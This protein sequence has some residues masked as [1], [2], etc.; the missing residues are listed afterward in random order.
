MLPLDPTFPHGAPQ[1]VPDRVRALVE[2][3]GDLQKG[4]LHF[5]QGSIIVEENEQNEHVY[6]I[7]D[8][9]VQMLKHSSINPSLEVDR[10]GPGDLLGLTSFWSRE[11]SFLRSVALTEVRCLAIDSFDLDQLTRRDPEVRLIIHRLFISNLSNRYRRMISLNVRVAELGD[12]LHREHAQLK[13]AIHDLEQTRNRLIHQEKLATLGQLLAGIAHEINNPCAA[14]SQGVE[15]LNQ[16]LPQLLD[17]THA[18]PPQPVHLSLFLAGL[19]ASYPTTEDKRSRRDALLSRHPELP[20]SLARRLARLAPDLLPT[21]QLPS[22]GSLKSKDLQRI[23]SL[24]ATYELGTHLRS[25]RLSSERIQ[26]LVVSLKNYGRQDQP[27]AEL[28]DLRDGIHDTLT[29]LNHRLKNYQLS[30]DLQ[31]IPKVLVVGSEINQVWT[32]L[33]TNACQATPTGGHLR[34]TASV[35]EES[36]I[37]QVIDS[38]TGIRPDLL[39]RIFETNFTT[40]NTK[41]DFGL[42][43]GLAISRE[44]IEKHAGSIQA[45]N[46]PDGG[47]TF[48]VRLPLPPQEE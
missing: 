38:G 3:L 45:T 26:K 7:L 48:T 40:K 11:P 4:T 12:A 31:E 17:P 30:L 20:R 34:I 21:L 29:V 47:A 35:D 43:L 39:E 5:P 41:S 33:L 42:G 1:T 32:N 6:V 15:S 19:E 2:K 36:V 22:K 8:G 23:E 28:F 16:A 18:I 14:L 37:V 13:Q 24:L 44:I 27:Q 9:E 10:F 46:N 25:I